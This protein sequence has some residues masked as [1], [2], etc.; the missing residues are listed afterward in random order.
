MMRRS[1]TAKCV[2]RCAAEKSR[3][4]LRGQVQLGATTA[5][6]PP[7]Q[8]PP[9][10]RPPAHSAP[11]ETLPKW[12]LI[13]PVLRR[14]TAQIHDRAQ[15]Q[16]TTQA[17]RVQKQIE[18]MH[19]KDDPERSGHSSIPQ[20]PQLPLREPRFFLSILQPRLQ[21]CRHQCDGSS[22]FAPARSP[23]APSSIA[24]CRRATVMS[25]T[26]SCDR[27]FRSDKLSAGI[28]LQNAFGAIH[29]KPDQVRARFYA[30]DGN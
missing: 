17:D 13:G 22:R 24:R 15:L 19:R 3:Y 16:R 28:G 2:R 18:G 14:T 25:Q 12:R 8:S 30:G 9:N 1:E 6:M 5:K 11:I 29:L 27:N 20:W 7:A 10:S 4:F 23:Y 21:V 26:S